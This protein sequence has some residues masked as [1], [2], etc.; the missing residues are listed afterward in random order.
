MCILEIADNTGGEGGNAVSV[1]VED[2]LKL[3]S[4]RQAKVLGGAGGLK[5]VVSSI[6]V[7][8]A[9][10]PSVL[11][12]EVF[13]QDKYFGSEI[14]ITG[15]LNCIH[16]VDRQCANLIRLAEGGEV[17]L[18][19]YYVGVY[20]PYV[21][22]KLI[23]IA[24][25]RDF[26]LICMPEGQRHLRYSDLIAD[27][28]ECIYRDRITNISLVSDILARVSSAPPHQQTVGTALQMLCAE[29]SCSVV[30]CTSE[31]RILNLSTWPSGMEERIHAGFR[32]GLSLPA[33][34]VRLPCPFL[35]DA[36]LYRVPIPA[37]LAQP[38]Q[39][40]LI[41]EG[42][43]LSRELVEQAADMTRICVNIWGRQNGAVAVHEL[44]RAILQDEPLK[45]RRLAEIFHIDIAAIHELWMLCGADAD[46]AS[47]QMEQNLELARQCADITFG[48][49]Y[50]GQPVMCLSTPHSL[51]DTERVMRELLECAAK[52][53]P[54]AVI[55]RCSGLSN[56]TNCRRAYLLTLENLED[57]KCIF[58]RKRIF[59]LGEMEL[60]AACRKRISEGEAAAIDE[61]MPLF[62]LQS[63]G[64]G[65]EL[66]NTA[67]AYLLDCDGSVTRTA[68]LLHL[69]KN[70]IKYRLQRISDTLGFR[71]GKMPE[72]IELYYSAA[73]CRLLY[74]KQ[75]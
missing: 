31:Y 22:Q 2:I 35:P 25:E 57:A 39:L 19:L 49:V 71:L 34:E 53:S 14:V 17:G 72:T 55:V 68:E 44:L 21:D 41:K 28:T 42:K 43:P 23:D 65:T 66:L 27:V 50:E 12:K 73:I 29:L 64:D 36:E 59:L 11:V 13:P 52:S 46:V 74:K 16:D 26:V 37:D 61:T 75:R 40:F 67:C 18:V 15:F 32:N 51:R 45:M 20:L 38:L 3:P 10:D 4:L 63:D 6:S 70:T 60:A 1:T 9:T 5:K 33:G 30:L 69:H 48:S 8:E 7:L 24:N 62:A 56:T 54:D 58:P 47:A